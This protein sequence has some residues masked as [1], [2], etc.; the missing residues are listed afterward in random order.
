MRIIY[1][2]DQIVKK[3][4]LFF[5]VTGIT[6]FPTQALAEDRDAGSEAFGGRWGRG[7]PQQAGCVAQGVAE[8]FQAKW[9]ILAAR[10][11]R[12][13]K[14]FFSSQVGTLGGSEKTSRIALNAFCMNEC[15]LE[16]HQGK[17]EATMKPRISRR[18]L[19]GAALGL[20]GAPALVSAQDAYPNRPI[21]LVVPSPAGGGTDFSARLIA[22]RP[23]WPDW[24]CFLP[25]WQLT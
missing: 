6:L 23:L 25:R 13:N 21:T 18:T 8:Y 14:Q 2:F 9:L 4:L 7:M 17:G 16:P 3:N 11:M 19:A 22:D 24:S 1:Y 20:L 5:G 10:K 12:S 15:E